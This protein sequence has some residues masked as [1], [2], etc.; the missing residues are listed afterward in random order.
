[1]S[2]LKG[3]F[4]FM[5]IPDFQTIML[6]LLKFCADSFEHTRKDTID[7]LAREFTITDEERRQL[8]PSGSQ[9]ILIIVSH[10]H[11]LI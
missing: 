7:Y 5:A 4:K 11:G 1:M 3:A 9:N 6:P 8:L 10:G 2:L